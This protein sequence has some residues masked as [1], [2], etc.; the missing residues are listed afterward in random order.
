MSK[1]GT[2]RTQQHGITVE[3]FD[4]LVRSDRYDF[5]SFHD[6]LVAALTLD[7]TRATVSFRY[8]LH[9]GNERPRVKDFA[10]FIA[11]EIVDYA[12]PRSEIEEARQ[13]DAEQSTTRHFAALHK[14]AL[15]LFTDIANTGEGG[16]LLLY[17]LAESILRI[18]QVLCKMPLKTSGHVHYHGSDGVHATVDDATGKLALYWGESKL[19]ASVSSAMSECFESLTPFLLGAGGSTS[20]QQRDLELLCGNV[21]LDDAALEAALLQYLDPKSVHFQ[22]LEYRGL[23]LVGFDVDDYP[24][25]PN[26]KCTT[27]V[28]EALAKRVDSWNKSLTGHITRRRLESFELQV[29]CLPFPSV[30]AFRQAFLAELGIT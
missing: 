7:D 28:K 11:C 13:L 24:S 29:F 12:I 1:T 6:E 21:D 5:D 10:R 8:L 17:L 23:C 27:E 14:K 22:N 2:T 9:D 26:Q 20:A 19:H 18:P 25:E 16:E 30:E 15:S 3:A 4:R